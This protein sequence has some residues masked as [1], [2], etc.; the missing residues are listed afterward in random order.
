M[1]TPVANATSL[2]SEAVDWAW[3]FR[4]GEHLYSLVGYATIGYRCCVL[5]S[6]AVYSNYGPTLRDPP[7]DAHSGQDV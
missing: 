4:Y 2:T 5:R 1:M 6:M 7:P 3:R